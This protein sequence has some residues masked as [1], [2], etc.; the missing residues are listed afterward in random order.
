MALA[1]GRRRLRARP[2]RRPRR[3][4]RHRR[5]RH[6][7]RL[8]PQRLPARDPGW[9]PRFANLTWFGW[10]ANHI[11]LA[12][13]FDWAVARARRASS[14]SSSSS[15]GVEAFVA[16]RPRRD[17]HRPDPEPAAGPRRPARADR[18]GDRRSPAVGA[19][20]GPRHRH[21][22]PR[23]RRLAASSF[24]DQLN[25]SPGLRASCSRPIFPNI[26]IASVGGFLQLAVRRVRPHPRRPRRGDARR[27][28]GPRTRPSGRLEFLLATPLSRPRWVTGRRRRRCSSASSVVTLVAA[29]GIAIGAA[30]TGGDVATPVVGHARARP[31]RCGAGIGIGAAVG[32]VFG[33]RAS[34]PRSSR[35]RRS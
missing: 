2:V 32:G 33:G 34:R 11:P 23:H 17:E 15:I 28:A 3:R 26:D 7:R 6:V 5:R 35:S 30:I 27:R 16:A 8:H 12:G 14:R 19:G 29:V 13:Q 31:V 9:S 10:T 20:L 4:G 18:P 1:A 22:R 21:L 25:D 24:V